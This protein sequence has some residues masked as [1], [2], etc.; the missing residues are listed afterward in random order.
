MPG[1]RLAL[2]AMTFGNLRANAQLWRRFLRELRFSHWE[3]AVALPRMRPAA[4]GA[5]PPCAD[6]AGQTG[7]SA[8]QLELVACHDIMQVSS[9]GDIAGC[10][11][12]HRACTWAHIHCQELPANLCA[13]TL[14][15]ALSAASLYAGPT[16]LSDPAGAVSKQ[17]E[18]GSL[19]LAWGLAHQKLQMV[20]LCISKRAAQVR[21]GC[22]WPVSPGFINAAQAA[23]PCCVLH[24][25]SICR[26]SRQQ[27]IQAHNARTSHTRCRP[28]KKHVVAAPLGLAWSLH[29]ATHRQRHAEGAA[30]MHRQRTG[31]T[32]SSGSL[33]LRLQSTQAGAA[34]AAQMKMS[35]G[36]MPCPLDRAW[37]KQ[38]PGAFANMFIVP[39]GGEPFLKRG[40]HQH[41]TERLSDRHGLLAC[42]CVKLP[43]C[44]CQ[45]PHLL[46]QS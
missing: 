28:M 11:V 22:V 12:C 35:A 2:H 27:R 43:P 36:T 3:P 44:P 6:R 19:D 45:V 41:A 38:H 20:A 31:Q 39:D 40:W 8:Q 10:I 13:S 32:C 34:T 9:T 33:R 25:S 16:R 4:L 30:R 17:A 5:S 26:A 15:P 23:A 37:M 14:R 42:L 21:S 18:A 1:G 7:S 46:D 29:Q 24:R